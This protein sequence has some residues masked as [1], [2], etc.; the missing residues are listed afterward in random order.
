MAATT[1][2]DTPR[3][4]RLREAGALIP[5]GA[6][7]G[8]R[9]AYGEVITRA[10]GAYLWN[11][12]GRRYVDHLNA[13]GPIVIAHCEAALV[14]AGVEADVTGIGSGWIVNWRATPP[15]TFREAADADLDR[16]E[17]FRPAML[18]AGILLPPYV[19]TAYRINRAFTG[20][21]VDET[22]AAARRA[23]RLVR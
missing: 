15:V 17:A 19:I 16:G 1:A 11:P 12:E 18:D 13:Y 23:A 9:A 14:D 21:D 7:A 6:S 20:D 2:I 4:N 8:G 5:G 3:A 22:I 10:E